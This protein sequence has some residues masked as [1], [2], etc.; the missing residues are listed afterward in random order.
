VL[1]NWADKRGVDGI[2]DYWREKNQISI[3][4]MPTEIID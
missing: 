4:G 1:N 2:R 3:D